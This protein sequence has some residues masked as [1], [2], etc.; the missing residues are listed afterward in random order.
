M[1]GDSASA[2][3]YNHGVLPLGQLP[4]E[5]AKRKIKIDPEFDFI[6]IGIV[7]PL[8]DYRLAWFINTVMFKSLSKMEDRVI[9]DP[10][11]MRQMT[12][13]RYDYT[14]EITKSVFH[15][16]QNKH[17]AECL[18]PEMKNI[19]YLLIIKGD[20]YKSRVKEIAKKLR[21]VEQIQAVV[22]LQTEEVKSKNNLVLED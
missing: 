19:D 18:L 4:A 17:A 2:P 14:E 22:I 6:L 8:Q 10:V 21:T 7:S 1:C 5:V 12:F 13:S 11:N 9:T 3:G 16:L 15:L 20:Y